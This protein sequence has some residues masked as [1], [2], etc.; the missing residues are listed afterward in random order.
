MN[1]NCVPSLTSRVRLG[2][3]RVDITP[4]VGIYHRMWG[5]ARHDRSTGVHKPLLGDVMAI[6]TADKAMP[7]L[8]RTHLDLVNLPQGQHKELVSALSEACGVPVDDTI[9]SHSHTHAAGVLSLSRLKFPGG[10]LIPGFL[11]EMRSRLEQASKEAVGRMQE[12]FITYATGRCNMAANRDCWDE[13]YGH[14]VCGFNP[15][16]PADDTV[17]VARVTDLSGKLV[18]TIVNYAC[19]ATTLAYE[20]TLIS[21][22]FVGAMREEVERVTGAPCIFAQGACGDLGPRYDYVGGPAIADQ[23]GRWLAYAALSALESMGPPATDYQYE[24]PVVSGAT[25]GVWQPAYLSKERLEQVSGFKGGTYAVDLPLKPKPDSQELEQEMAQ[26]LARQKE[27]DESG[28]TIAARDYG[29]RAERARRWLSR[30]ENLPEGTTYPFHFS[31]HHMGDAF[32]VTCGGEPYNLL[33]RELRR[34]FPDVAILLSPLSGDHSVAYL[35]QKDCYGKG[36]YQEEP[37][38]LAPGCLEK[39]IEAVASRIAELS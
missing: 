25:L 21:P 29:A 16:A 31:V 13:A 2:F 9:V 4:P 6:G 15:E 22:D 27:A 33:Q 35:L 30:L 32:W 8:L 38:I 24:G 10:E 34:R 3:A 11:Q 28:D 7:R 17:L 20:N 37:S 19:H 39:L 26:W 23:N 14:F 18:V 12:V 1:T 5:A 36:L